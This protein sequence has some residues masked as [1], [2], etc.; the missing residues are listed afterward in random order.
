MEHREPEPRHTASDQNAQST[1]PPPTHEDDLNGGDGDTLVVNRGSTVTDPDDSDLTVMVARHSDDE[2]GPTIVVRRAQG[3]TRKDGHAHPA[4]RESIGQRRRGLATP[5]VPPGFAPRGFEGSGA[6][7]R[8]R[9][10]PR[11]IPTPPPG[12]SAAVTSPAASREGSASMPS[13]ARRTRVTAR[14][15]MALFA[16][17]CVVSVVGLTLIALAV[18][19]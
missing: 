16:T 13:V 7:A 8:E 17:A 11:A 14:L 5:P 6:G 3:A 12:S 2:A 15:A 19:S 9:Y 4:T 18:F 10:R 1:D